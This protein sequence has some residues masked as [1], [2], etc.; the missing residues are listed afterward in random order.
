MIGLFALIALP[1]C[2]LAMRVGSRL[3]CSNGAG[4]CGSSSSGQILFDEEFDGARLDMSAWQ[5]NWL[6]PNNTAITKPING[7]EKSCY[8]PAQVSV[9]GGSLHL[10]AVARS[11]TANNG[12]TYRY[13]SGLVNT[14]GRFT[15][16]YGH[17]E[18][19][20]WVPSG[21]G[22]VTNWPAFWADGT[23]RWPTTGEN[24]VFEGLSGRDCYH[25]HSPS[26]G[27]GGCAAAANPSGWHVF[28]A[29][30]SPGSV[31]YIYDGTTV[32]SVTRGITKAPMYLILNLGVGGFG[33]ALQAP[34]TMLVDYVRV[35]KI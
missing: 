30:W 34:A 32:G 11:C 27:P 1:G 29:E 25:F 15:F 35:W 21:S 22:A 8:D 5:P 10:D 23:G 33:G 17:L 4:S 13:A 20:V 7:V 14:L 24:D 19:R 31:T 2:S 9:S 26:G 3:D 18:A 6:G 12:T 16:T 28:A